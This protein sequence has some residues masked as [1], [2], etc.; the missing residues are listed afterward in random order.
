MAKVLRT[1]WWTSDPRYSDRADRQGP[2]A[3]HRSG[4]LASPYQVCGD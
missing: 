4:R 2:R 3:R 1:P